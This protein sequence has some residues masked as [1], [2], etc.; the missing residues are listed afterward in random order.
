[1]SSL[2]LFASVSLLRPPPLFLIA[3][4]FP[5]ALQVLP[6]SAGLLLHFLTLL[7]LPTWSPRR[8]LLR[9]RLPWGPLRVTARPFR[10]P[11]TQG[12]AGRHPLGG[13]G[14]SH[15]WPVW[16]HRFS[17]QCSGGLRRAGGPSSAFCLR[18]PGAWGGGPRGGGE[19][20]V[21]VGGRPPREEAVRIAAPSAQTTA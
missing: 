6:G 7:P 8:C 16:P 3:C 13:Q 14:P 18:L 10:G 4:S 19:S 21:R 5:W 9:S 12:L 17:S 11:R 2:L 1:M 15:H 20:G